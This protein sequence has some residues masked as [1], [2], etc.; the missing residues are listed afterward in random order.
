MERGGDVPSDLEP[1]LVD[2]S[3]FGERFIQLGGLL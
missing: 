3:V 2:S 1:V